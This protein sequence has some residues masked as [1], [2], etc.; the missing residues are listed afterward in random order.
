MILNSQNCSEFLLLLLDSEG[1]RSSTLFQHTLRVA[2]GNPLTINLHI[3]AQYTA[4]NKEDCS[5]MAVES[6]AYIR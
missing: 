3:R 2:R 6:G 5:L 1:A 4:I